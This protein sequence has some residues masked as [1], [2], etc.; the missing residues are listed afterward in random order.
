MASLKEQQQ[1]SKTVVKEKED[2]AMNT[3]K[4]FKVSD[5]SKFSMSTLHR[6]FSHDEDSNVLGRLKRLREVE[7]KVAVAAGGEY[8]LLKS[9]ARDSRSKDAIAF[10]KQFIGDAGKVL[11]GR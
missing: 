5:N 2:I 9:S 11:V 8:T 1:N 7:K 6:L 10:A 3:R 4:G